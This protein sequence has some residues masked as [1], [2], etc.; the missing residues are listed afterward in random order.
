VAKLSMTARPRF[1]TAEANDVYI[2]LL[3][4]ATSGRQSDADFAANT[5]RAA[6]LDPSDKSYFAR[7]MRAYT[8]AHRDWLK[9]SNR[10]HRMRLEWEEFFAEW[11]VFLSPAAASAAFPHDH[12]G[13]RHERT[14]EV[15]GH[16][17]PTTDQL[18]WAGYTGCFY[19]PAT[20]APAG[21]TPQGL[22][23]GV[24]IAAAEHEDLTAIAFARLLER[25]Y[26]GFVPPPMA[27]EP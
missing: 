4:A 6:A 5:A 9:M 21:F 17:V 16:R 25:E 20:V 22:P 8:M 23:V 13:E 14:I 12:E 27:V 2:W 1:S 7:M 18:F 11:D 19:L 10:R 3:R 26:Q 15:N 24:Q